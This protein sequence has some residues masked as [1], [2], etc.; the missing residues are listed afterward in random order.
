ML[1]KFVNIAIAFILC[2]SLNSVNVLAATTTVTTNSGYGYK[3]WSTSNITEFTD[4][5][6][7]LYNGAVI[8]VDCS[9]NSSYCDTYSGLVEDIEYYENSV[10]EYT[11]RAEFLKIVA[12]AAAMA[13]NPAAFAAFIAAFTI[14]ASAKD[15]AR[16]LNS[17]INAANR[18]FK[19][20]Y[21]R[22]TS[23]SLNECY[24][25]GSQWVCKWNI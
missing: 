25:T 17:S 9:K 6:E 2:F 20:L 1:K 13:T 5:D 16:K 10:A 7:G 23:E 21:S 11:S 14:E 24:W 8:Y 19:N 3:I 18:A 12:A 22:Q 4:G 15:A